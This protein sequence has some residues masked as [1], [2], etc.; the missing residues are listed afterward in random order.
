MPFIFP[1]IERRV[2]MWTFLKDVSLRL[3]FTPVEFDMDG[4][5]E[6]L[7]RTFGLAKTE[8]LSLDR[9]HGIKIESQDE[10]IG[11]S[12]EWDY[13]EIKL[14][15]PLYKSFDNLIQWFPFIHE[16]IQLRNVNKLSKLTIAKYNEL[17]YLIPPTE[18]KTVKDAMKEIFSTNLLD[19]EFERDSQGFNTLNRWEKK[20]SVEDEEAGLRV[21]FSFG[22][23]GKNDNATK[24]VLTLYTFVSTSGIETPLKNIDKYLNNM[25]NVIDDAFHWSVTSNIIK[26]MEGEDEQGF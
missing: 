4:V 26:R 10:N 17:P 25:N 2:Y 23:F 21:D 20:K 14:R 12:F 3:N 6:L 5:K 7:V 15:F 1:K 8:T 22:F 16:Y 13:L 24:G 11:F 18:G 9:D 19:E